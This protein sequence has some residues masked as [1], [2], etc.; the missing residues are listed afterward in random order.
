MTAAAP[1]LRFHILT[2]D[3]RAN[4]S[5]TEPCW[6]AWSQSVFAALQKHPWRTRSRTRAAL[7]F[8]AI[9]S[10]FEVNYPVF[11]G[12]RL[13]YVRAHGALCDGF[14]VRS[15]LEHVHRV[16]D[17]LLSTATPRRLVL[18]PPILAE[19]A[20]EV[21]LRWH[22]N[23]GVARVLTSGAEIGIY[24]TDADVSFPP[25]SA[26]LH[27][28]A[29]S[30]AWRAAGA[31]AS[32]CA[33]TRHLL[34]YDGSTIRTQNMDDAIGREYVARFRARLARLHAPAERVH[35]VVCAK[36][37]VRAAKASMAAA[38]TAS[39]RGEI[40]GVG[41]I[42]GSAG[43]GGGIGGGEAANVSADFGGCAGNG[44]GSVPLPVALNTTFALVPR[45]DMPYAYR[46]IEALAFGAV[47]VVLADEYVLP[48][49]EILDWPAFAVRWPYARVSSL[50]PYLRSL[51]P[52]R[53]CAMRAAAATAWREHFSS[54]E[55]QV[56]TM[57]TV[58]AKHERAR[59]T[60]SQ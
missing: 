24:R 21:A 11:S 46:L 1:P 17:R 53:V 14:R 3:A 30:A 32:A 45:G 34:A 40:G 33:P 23:A 50:V 13:G 57:L 52:E 59:A 31:R 12:P 44:A 7:Q 36:R 51:P 26:H 15:Y 8:V 35:I 27:T 5:A 6:T 58:L 54:V 55:A 19:L 2:S 49:S 38:G 41:G 16:I 56:H 39:T 9:E 10:R 22:H 43:V 48:F 18:F 20:E 60:R 25:S 4:L 47:P 28:P 29:L 37:Q 42:G